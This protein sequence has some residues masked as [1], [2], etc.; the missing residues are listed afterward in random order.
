MSITVESIQDDG[1]ALLTSSDDMN[2]FV[3]ENDSKGFQQLLGDK[4]KS[5]RVA[6]DMSEAT[7]IDSAAIGWLLLMNKSFT[8]AGGK[9]VIFGITPSVMRVITLLRIGDV[10]NITDDREQALELVRE[11]A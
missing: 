7:Y 6:L 10:L 2:A 11:G 9:F 3:L 4:W 1:V 5:K 8:E